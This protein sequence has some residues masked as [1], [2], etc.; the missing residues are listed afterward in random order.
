MLFVQVDYCLF[1]SKLLK[2]QKLKAKQAKQL[3]KQQVQLAK[4]QAKE[5]IKKEQKSIII[6]SELKPKESKEPSI[7][8][9]SVN[10]S[11]SKSTLSRQQSKVP[12]FE[13]IYKKQF[14]PRIRK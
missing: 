2:D 13:N 5:S 4:Q 6:S 11:K 8:I 10:K 3:V 1:C 12:N 14:I 7:S 9:D